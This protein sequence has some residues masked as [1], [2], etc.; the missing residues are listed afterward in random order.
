[1]IPTP[2]GRRFM[3]E[4]DVRPVRDRAP[5]INSPSRDRG[6]RPA[7][8]SSLPS[9]L[10]S[11]PWTLEESMAELRK[12]LQWFYHERDKQAE[13]RLQMAL[14]DDFYDSIQWDRRTQRSRIP[15]PDSTGVQR[16]RAHGGLAHRHR[17]PDAGGL[18]GPAAYR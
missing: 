9:G 3:A 1:M 16:D 5:G 4:F 18:V 11:T 6:H 15:W 13:N 10:V 7:G 12:L 8:P 2:W 17:A 14:D